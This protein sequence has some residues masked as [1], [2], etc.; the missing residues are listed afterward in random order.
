MRWLTAALLAIALTTGVAACFGGAA[1][2]DA[3]ADITA[4]PLPTRPSLTATPVPLSQS[5]AERI[6]LATSQTADYYLVYG[7]TSKEIGHHMRTNGPTTSAGERGLG[8]AAPNVSLTWQ[9]ETRAGGCT[10]ASMTI[11]MSVAVTLPQHAQLEELSPSLSELWREFVAGIAGHE[12]RHVDIYFDGV[13]EIRDEIVVLE[14]R[15]EA[16]PALELTI[17][18]LWDEG[19][20]RIKTEQDRFHTQEDARIN[21]ARTSLQAQY[22]AID[23]SLSLLRIEISSLDA[24]VKALEAQMEVVGSQA[25]PLAAQMQA[26]KAEFPDLTLVPEISEQFEGLRVA[27][28]SL[29]VRYEELLEERDTLLARRNVQAAQH[30]GLVEQ[31]NELVDRYNLTP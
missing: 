3:V 12:Q 6:K 30:D 31:R 19:L 4:T 2:P 14:E 13:R 23:P 22:E 24:N 29:I 9:P 21:A 10:I 15:Q 16:C 20:A 7:R 18:S 8:I 1:T 27:Y 17:Q 5:P 11:S 25:A 28:N 26:I